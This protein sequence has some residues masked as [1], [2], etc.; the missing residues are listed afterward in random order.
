MKKNWGGRIIILTV[1]IIPTQDEPDFC[2]NS[3]STVGTG[4]EPRPALAVLCGAEALEIPSLRPSAGWVQGSALVS[5]QGWSQTLSNHRP[6]SEIVS[7]GK[8]NVPS[9]KRRFRFDVPFFA[10]SCF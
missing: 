10:A 1:S 9:A 2:K 8:E 4:S 3:A 5:S 7:L 6:H